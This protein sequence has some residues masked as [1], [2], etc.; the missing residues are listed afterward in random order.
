MAAGSMAQVAIAW[1]AFVAWAIASFTVLEAVWPRRPGWPGVRRIALATALLAIDS[2]VAGVLVRP[3][4]AAAPVARLAAAWLV[5][6]LLMYGVHR[7]MHR[8]PWL[9]RFHRLHHAD[10][11]LAW[12]TGWIIHPIDA[13]LFAACAV[14]G[15]LVAGAG[16]PGAAWFLVGRRVWTLVLHANLAWPA[17]ALDRAIATPPFHHRHHREDLAPANFAS[18]LPLLDQLFGTYAEAPPTHA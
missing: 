6:E 14:G 15:G 4:A 1:G 3:P 11:P 17:S 10:A 9:W 16:V 13:A 5:T 7:A 2:A 8:V 12:S 18:T